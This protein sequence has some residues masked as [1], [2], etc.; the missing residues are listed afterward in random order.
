M[1]RQKTLNWVWGFAALA[2]AAVVFILPFAFIFL[3]ASKSAV[4]AMALKFSWPTEWHLWDNIVQVIQDNNYMLVRAFNNSI[5]LTIF[6]VAVMVVL[7]ATTAYIIDRRPGKISKVANFLVLAGLTIPPAV[8]PTIFILQFF[9]IYG[10]F[11][12]MVLIEVA[13][14]TSFTV[15]IFRAFISSI[16]RELDEA[17]VIDGAGPLR[18]FFSVIFPLLKSVTVTAIILNSVFI[19]NDFTNPLYFMNGAGSE[20]VQLT[21][22]NFNS[23]YLSN[24]N[25]LF[26]DILLITVPMV[27]MFA[28]FNRRIVAGMTAGSVKG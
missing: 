21:L 18:L 7:C 1:K 8:V 19:F 28:I 20:T 11:F 26:A 17:A 13:Y 6:S 25:L 16:P 22:F 9:H 12:S 23:Q 4:E 14:G 15:M 2:I 27:I 5:W 24:Y 3:T 10:T